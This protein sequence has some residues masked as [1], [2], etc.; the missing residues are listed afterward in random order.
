VSFANAAQYGNDA[1]IAPE[2][3]LRDG[4]L[5]LC[6]MK[7]FPYTSALT[8]GVKLFNR[9]LHQSPYLEVVRTREVVVERSGPGPIHLD[10]EPHWMQASLHVRLVPASLLVLAGKEEGI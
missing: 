2:A 9:T 6:V 5:D 8:L 10:G 1:F 4:L 7:P 3:S